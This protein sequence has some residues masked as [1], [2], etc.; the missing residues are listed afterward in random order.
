[1]FSAIASRATTQFHH[2]RQPSNCNLGSR[3]SGSCYSLVKFSSAGL[4]S[5][6]GIFDTTRGF[7]KEIIFK[8]YVGTVVYGLGREGREGGGRGGV[9]WVD[10]SVRGGLERR[11]KP[12][13]PRRHKVAARVRARETLRHGRDSM[14]GPHSGCAVSRTGAEYKMKSGRTDGVPRVARRQ[15]EWVSKRRKGGASTR[16]SEGVRENR[17]R[18]P[19]V[20]SGYE[21]GDD[22]GKG[23]GRQGCMG[24][25][26]YE[27]SR[28]AC[29][30]H[31]VLDSNWRGFEDEEHIAGGFDSA[32]EGWLGRGAI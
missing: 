31:Y 12:T 19:G 21:G 32:A 10:D 20:G 9:V 1:M 24:G 27:A 13:P 4:H 25:G 5:N 22:E 11:A 2:K 8:D 28:A 16:T 7:G 23:R 30:R 15:G 17:D 18:A 6:G 26:R 29:V 14:C 3:D